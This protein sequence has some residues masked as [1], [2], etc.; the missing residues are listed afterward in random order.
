MMITVTYRRTLP[1]NSSN[2]SHS[3]HP[4][5]HLKTTP[6]TI[7]CSLASVSCVMLPVSQDVGVRAP[8]D[9]R[10]ELHDGNEATQ[11]VYLSSLVLPIH[12]P[13]QVEQF[14][15]LK[16]NRNSLRKRR[17]C[18]PQMKQEQ[19]LD[20]KNWFTSNQTQSANR[21]GHSQINT[22]TW[23]VEQIHLKSIQVQSVN[24][25]NYPT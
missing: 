17:T 14:G 12:H 4:V 11:V 9:Q 13:R 5:N 22:L 8:P 24:K 21:I 15:T 19:S 25:Y 10:P 18:Q 6:C 3:S 20:K 7:G 16:S 23:Q 2:P 1:T